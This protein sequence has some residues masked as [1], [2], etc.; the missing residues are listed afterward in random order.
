MGI[1]AYFCGRSGKC[2][3]TNVIAVIV[4]ACIL[5]FG[6]FYGIDIYTHHGEQ[7]V[8]PDVTHLSRVE[9]MAQLDK[10]GLVAVVEDSA[11]VEDL[12]E[13]VVLAQLPAAGQKVK[14]GRSVALT[15]NRGSAPAIALPDLVRNATGRIAEQQLRQLGFTLTPPD[16]VLDEPRDLVVGIRQGGRDLQGGDM[17]A[18]GT[19]ITILVGAGIQDELLIDSLLFDDNLLSEEAPLTDDDL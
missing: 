9:A 1:K 5:L 10:E 15:I 8:V 11:Y 7:I 17:V 14:S 16:S 3:W 12:A 18:P 13:G 2:F 19:P 6:A 4:V